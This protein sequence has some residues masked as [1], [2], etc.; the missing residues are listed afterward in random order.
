M[1]KDECR[2]QNEEDERM[3][4]LAF[5]ASS[6]AASCALHRE[7]HTLPFRQCHTAERF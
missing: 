5:Q 4:L 3:P 6:A 1:Q 7:E 2:M